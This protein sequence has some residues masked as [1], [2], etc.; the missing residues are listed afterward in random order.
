[1]GPP[2]LWQPEDKWPSYLGVEELCEDDPE[3]K[4]DAKVG[5]VLTV[6]DAIQVDQ[7][8]ERFSSWHRLKKFVPWFLKYK[9]SLR[10]FCLRHGEASDTGCEV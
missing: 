2:F 4:K 5:G 1:M 8:L 3:V 7:L 10:K 9:T 6:G